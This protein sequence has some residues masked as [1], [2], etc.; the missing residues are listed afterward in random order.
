MIELTFATGFMLYLGLT[1]MSVLGVWIYSHYHTR[2]R[3][4]FP[5][6]KTLFLCEF[7]HYAY[8]DESVKKLNRCPQCGLINKK[9]EYSQSS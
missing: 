2:R 6:E 5:I 8:V 3:V 1:L 9:N 4:F 7:C